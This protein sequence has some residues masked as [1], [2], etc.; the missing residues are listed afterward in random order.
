MKEFSSMGEFALELVKLEA[1]ELMSLSHGLEKVAQGIEKTARDE[2]GHYQQA[3]GPFPAWAE[4][5]ESTKADRLSHGFTEND[6]GLRIGEMQDS[7]HHETKWL[8]AVIGS[9]DQ[10]LVWFEMGTNKQ[11]PRPVLG[12]AVVHNEKL[13]LKEIGHAAVQGLV[14]GTAISPQLGYDRNV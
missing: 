5:A 8:E 14:P 4:L 6:P 3:A 12:P 11:P 1:A 13:I 7:I 2:I 10:N 9:D